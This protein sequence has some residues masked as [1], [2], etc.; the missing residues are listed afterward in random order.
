MS[1]EF[2]ANFMKLNHQA[3][4]TLLRLNEPETALDLLK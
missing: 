3:I 2:Y 4:E 1:N